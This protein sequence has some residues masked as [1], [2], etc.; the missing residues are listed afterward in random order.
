MEPQTLVRLAS[1]KAVKAGQ[2][3]HTARAVTDLVFEGDAVSGKVRGS[4]PVPHSTSLKLVGQK[5]EAHCTC[6]TFTDGW[7]KICH[8]AVALG[9]TLREQYEKGA[10]ITTTQNPW[11]VDVE[12]T[13]GASQRRY[14]IVQR[15]GSWYVTEFQAGTAVAVQ[16]RK[17]A[18]RDGLGPAD[19]LIHHYL[20]Q[21]LD[22][23][24]DG[25]HELDDPALA[26]L[27]FFARHSQ[28][29][30]K[31]VGKLKFSSEPLVMRVQAETRK[32]AA[33]EL[34]A[35]L[36]HPPTGRI[37]EVDQG[38]VVA[39]APTWYIAPETCEVFPVFDTP[40]WVLAA[41]ANQPR[42]VMDSRMGAQQMDSLSER[43][44]TV[45]VPRHD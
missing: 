34:H 29:S 24:D 39:G 20:D 19:R 5:L 27:L 30:L 9:L 31:G 44:Q 22:R 7:E 35:F 17:K 15:A 6:P 42:I 1:P 3:L 13:T 40:P 28:V 18:G 26:G 36:E 12:Q 21:E 45:G 2:E 10:E 38:R 4:H 32:D 23:S 37:F 14:Q 43:L 41:V 11:V 8:H 33:V 25:A 16:R